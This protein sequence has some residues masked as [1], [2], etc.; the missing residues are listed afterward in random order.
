MLY[1]L[2]FSTFPTSLHDLPDEKVVNVPDGRRDELEARV[3]RLERLLNQVLALVQ[4]MK[5]EGGA[6]SEQFEQ[7]PE[8][9][10]ERSGPV[11]HAPEPT[12]GQGMEDPT[13]PA[14]EPP[15]DPISEPVPGARRMGPTQDAG[16]AQAPPG[17]TFKTGMDVLE[18]LGIYPLKGVFLA[19]LGIVLLLLSVAY[20]FKYS[21]DQGW[22]VPAI[23]L[24][25]GLV[26]GIAMVALGFKGA[27]KGEPLGTAL[28][29]GG[30][31]TFFITGYTG[32]QWYSLVSYPVAFAFLFVASALGIFLSLRSGLQTLALVGLIG[33]LATPL[34][35]SPDSAEVVGLAL[36]VGLIVASVSAIYLLKAW[37]AL[38]VSAV[39]LAW[40]VLWLAVGGVS[41]SGSAGIWTVQATITFSAL[42]FWLVP[43]Y[44]VALRERN[45]GRWPRPASANEETGWGHQQW[46]V[47]LDALSLLMPLTAITFSSWMWD[48]SRVR[49]GW[50]FLSAALIAQAV[51]WWLART[52]DPEDSAT[53]Q[54]FVAILL[55]TVGLGLVLT[56]N[57]LYL[58]FMAEAVALFA[59]AARK[60]SKLLFGFGVAV[61]LIVL[62]TFLFRM[63]FGDF[64][65]EGSL[66]P[67][68]DV[69]AIAAAGLIGARYMGATGRKV[70][71]I[72]AYLGLLA[73]TAR[74]LNDH[75]SILY[76][77]IL[78]EA[79]VTQIVAVRMKDRV[80][81]N[82]SYV[83]FGFVV[84]G[85]VFGLQ[86]GR[87]LIGGD[88]TLLVDL[89]ALLGAIYLGT[90]ARAREVRHGFFVGAYVGLLALLARELLDHYGVL[91][92]AFLLVAVVTQVLASRTKTPLWAGVGH[93]PILVGL[94]FFADGMNGGRTLHA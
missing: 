85:F 64:L 72:G 93:L 9:P 60:G 71:F 5:A 83:A 58:A 12:F 69:A 79:V 77:A 80:V 31:A 7:V 87:T 40:A 89:A 4:E 63:V 81:E 25:L 45:P 54:R 57:V 76:L 19:R 6:P 59:V 56:G 28:A 91:Y 65:L 49:L 55:S 38:L 48:L 39:A 46:N 29:G 90:C 53:T 27:S 17:T 1:F 41:A 43:L 86:S 2:G 42:A 73:F 92:S 78:V 82:L 11:S 34:I 70:F 35:L 61:Q 74:E 66:V 37:R 33:A 10:A 84:L 21:I 36:Y 23:R 62:G 47:H 94:W 75:P 3:A 16:R 30:I 14:A 8:P 15:A 51:G 22:L 67:L 26:A 68:L 13:E 32:H 20:F 18:D 24:A 50:V 52:P 88:A 44:R